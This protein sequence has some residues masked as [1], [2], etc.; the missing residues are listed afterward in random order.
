MESYFVTPASP[1]IE[2]LCRM[3]ITKCQIAILPNINHVIM[4]P[5]AR[6]A[7]CDIDMR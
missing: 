1:Q 3:A 6:D 7:F 4:I 5:T 2:E